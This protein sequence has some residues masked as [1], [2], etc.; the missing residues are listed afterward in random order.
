MWHQHILDV[1]NYSHDM[2]LLCGRVVGHNPDG[3]MCGKAERDLTTRA[4]LERRFPN[5][6]EE[7]C[8]VLV[9]DEIISIRR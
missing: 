8:S 6:D 9:D 2:M 1:V 7:L 5:Y 3:A 4:A